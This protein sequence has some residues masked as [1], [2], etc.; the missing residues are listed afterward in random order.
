MKTRYRDSTRSQVFQI[1]QILAVFV[2]YRYQSGKFDEF[3]GLLGSLKKIPIFPEKSD[4]F[5][6]IRGFWH[7]NFSLSAK[8]NRFFIIL[9]GSAGTDQKSWFSRKLRFSRKNVVFCLFSNS[10]EKTWFFVDFL[11]RVTS[12]K[13]V[14]FLDFR[15][16]A[17]IG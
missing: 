10:S 13:I 7:T 1:F 5:V 15:C 9:G 2:D 14:V 6:K 4:F 8:F 3:R 17:W 16:F 12:R 11:K